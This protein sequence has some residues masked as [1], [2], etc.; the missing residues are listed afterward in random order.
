MRSKNA[1][2]N[3]ITS[4][5]CELLIF[6]FGLIM[7]RLIILTYGDAINGL[8]QT[9]TRL[10]SLIN[11][12]QAGAVGASIYQ[13]YKPVA[14]NDYD[15]QSAIIYSSQKY[16]NKLGKIY[17]IISVTIA[18][19]YSFYLHN[20][21][22]SVIEIFLSF[23]ILTLNSS[24][25]FF[26]TSK[27]DAVLSSY[28][29][30]YLL[31]IATMVERFIYYTL[32]LIIIHVKIHFVFMYLALLVGGL[33]RVL[34]NSTF[35]KKVTKGNIKNKPSNTT[36][37]IKDRKF[38]MMNSVGT[39][40][41][42]AAPTV[43]ITTF[44]GLVYSSV[45]SVYAM[46]YT[47]MKTIINSVHLSLSAIFG[48][49]V[50]KADN[51]KISSVFNTMLYVFTMLG[52]FLASCV[53]FLLTPFLD[54]YTS[55]FEGVNYKYQILVIFVTAYV[56]IFAF[57]M[58]FAFVSTVYGLFRDMCKITLILGSISVI[59]SIICT[60]SF[61][62]P[63]VMVGVLFFHLSY[64]ASLLIVY[65][66]KI[67]WFNFKKILRRIVFLIVLPAISYISYQL[68]PIVVTSFIEWLLIAFI[69]TFIIG[70]ILILYS[71]V[72]ERKEFFELFKYARKIFLN[73]KS[74][75]EKK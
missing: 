4:L 47:S 12:I 59:I 50:A 69:M 66:K 22:I 3:L 39:E 35:Y 13:M 17:F 7:P 45:F 65:K 71:V 75:K 36:F 51:Q 29:K 52:V 16:F 42:T 37:E 19:I 38:L 28:Q 21:S 8:T 10:L 33:V 61:G 15:T 30:R 11:L 23:T 40:M 62:M 58:V 41:I 2:K 72:F 70:A 24:L 54:I 63:Y 44:T 48:N 53:A 73:I 64:T 32:L 43:I 25:Y 34:I 57:R 55:G 26:F 46:I 5:S 20:E 68:H 31:V 49:L 56:A 67:V 27:Y 74:K 6:V 9:I 18:T 14:N 60:V 1:F